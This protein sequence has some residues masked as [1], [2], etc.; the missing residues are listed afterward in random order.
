MHVRATD[1][2]EKEHERKKGKR[3]V[4]KRERESSEVHV[5]LVCFCISLMYGVQ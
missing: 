5:S 1:R 4:R 3:G 2:G